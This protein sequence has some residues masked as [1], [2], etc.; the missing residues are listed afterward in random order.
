MLSWNPIFS[1]ENE[2][3]SFSQLGRMMS[4]TAQIL[5]TR[6]GR[7]ISP[8]VCGLLHAPN[9]HTEGAPWTD[10]DL[11]YSSHSAIVYVGLERGINRKGATTEFGYFGDLK[12]ETELSLL[13]NG[14]QVS[15]FCV[16]VHF[17]SF[18]KRWHHKSCQ[19]HVFAVLN[20]REG[21][22]WS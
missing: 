10:L 1:L 13:S 14:K 2:F 19:G 7:C 21:N 20:I 15:P 11:C 6:A 4:L 9:T 5:V 22:T 12:A 18:P 8:V 16:F 17:Q 3:C